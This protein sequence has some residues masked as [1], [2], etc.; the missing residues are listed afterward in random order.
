MMNG[1][2]EESLSLEVG[3]IYMS[4]FFKNL[5]NSQ[6]C[7]PISEGTRLEEGVLNIR[8]LALVAK[9]GFAVL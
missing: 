3:Q 8:F 4:K 6:F 1:R 9:R 7:V 5:Y 2:N